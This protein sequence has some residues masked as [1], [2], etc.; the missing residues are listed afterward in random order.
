MCG[1]QTIE[2][3]MGVSPARNVEWTLLKFTAACMGPACIEVH[4]QAVQVENMAEAHQ[5]KLEDLQCLCANC[6][7]VEH[8]LL[9]QRSDESLSSPPQQSGYASGVRY[10]GTALA[11]GGSVLLIERRLVP[12]RRTQN[13]LQE[14]VGVARRL[15]HGRQKKL[16]Y[17]GS[18]LPCAV[19]RTESF[20]EVEQP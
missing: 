15:P 7:R 11:G 19:I 6:H 12:L 3:V 13:E 17:V 10:F 20:G 14:H 2:R 1:A 4:H 9:K 16:P 8:R 5:T 18:K